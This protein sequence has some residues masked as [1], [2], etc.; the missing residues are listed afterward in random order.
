MFQII[1][2]VIDLC[3]PLQGPP[4]EKGMTGLSGPPG[5]DGEPGIKG[6]LW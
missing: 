1:V 2:C 3:F 6:K 4:G 5:K